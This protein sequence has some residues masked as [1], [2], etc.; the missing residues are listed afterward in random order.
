MPVLS[1]EVY[2][3]FMKIHTNTEYWPWSGTL[4][5]WFVGLRSERVHVTTSPTLGRLACNQPLSSTGSCLWTHKPGP[6]SPPYLVAG[7]E[8]PLGLL[9]LHVA[10]VLQY[11]AWA[12]EFKYRGYLC[13]GRGTI[14]KL[15]VGK[16]IINMESSTI[17][18]DRLSRH[19]DGIMIW[20]CVIGWLMMG[21]GSGEADRIENTW[22]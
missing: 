9:R 14:C 15:S 5:T 4:L 19:N 3:I 20:E 7:L 2:N 21:M 10:N 22:Q 13:F 6:G 16:W 8:Y 12:K 1:Q 18:Y 11:P 17:V